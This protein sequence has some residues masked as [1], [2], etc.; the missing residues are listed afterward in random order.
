MCKLFIGADPHLWASTSR[1]M[2]FDGMVSSVRLENFFWNTLE[3]IASRDG[4]TVSKLINRL[5]FESLEEGRDV[6]NLSSFLRVC[7]HRYLALQLAG[8][9][10]VSSGV[11]ISSL[12]VEQILEKEALQ[13]S[14]RGVARR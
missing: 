13:L 14:M 10:P 6:S 11:P 1:S 7:C 2:R 12:P 4:L 5:Y 9:I 8:L 3:E